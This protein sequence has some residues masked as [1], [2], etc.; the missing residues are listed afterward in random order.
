MGNGV[1]LSSLSDSDLDALEQGNY[2]KLSDS[3]LD[4]LESQ[5]STE[6][7]FFT[8]EEAPGELRP[9][10][11]VPQAGIEQAKKIAT[12]QMTNVAGMIP[13]P[14]NL[15][16]TA[17]A[18]ALQQYLQGGQVSPSKIGED[19]L[20]KAI[21]PT[22]AGGIAGQ[23]L[24]A[25]ATGWPGRFAK[26]GG[27]K[28]MELATGVSQA[29]PQ[30]GEKLAEAG[31]IGPNWLMKQQV[32]KKLPSAGEEVIE[33]A[34][35]IPQDI[36]IAKAQEKLENLIQ[37]RT[38]A[39]GG[40]TARGAKDIH[41]I[42]KAK[43]ELENLPGI[44]EV[45][46]KVLSAPQAA[47]AR[48]QYGKEAS[49]AGAYAK[50]TGAPKAKLKAEI[51]SAVQS[52]LSEE[53]KNAYAASFPETPN[54]LADK[55]LSFHALAKAREGLAS[56]DPLRELLSLGR[57]YGTAG[58]V[59]AVLAPAVGISPTVGAAIGST[60]ASPTFL[61]GAGQ[62]ISK[63]QQLGASPAFQKLIETTPSLAQVFTG[64]PEE[65]AK[66]MLDE[67]GKRL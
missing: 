55:D 15:P 57:R 16:A 9:A 53:L 65:E 5:A 59:G 24:K 48:V 51:P 1:N 47:S 40:S 49:E 43:E 41:K 56:R 62:A 30:A 21:V 6:S 7:P 67:F 23:T 31:I 22:T 45:D 34:S 35:S 10:V 17:G 18:S 58:T 19:V 39:E 8:T 25:V 50:R 27:G 46:G 52:G 28:L 54:V 3:G 4:Y 36:P 63:A 26:W 44:K 33:A 13:P 37:K 11:K 61:S 42:E 20:F 14:Y 66:K 12:E 2:S 38:L 60:L 29:A 64:L 32:A